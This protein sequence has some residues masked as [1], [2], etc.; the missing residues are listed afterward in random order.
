MIFADRMLYCYGEDGTM[1]LI[2]PDS[3]KLTLVSSFKI[4]DGSREHFAHPA[5]GDGVLYVRH[6]N[7]LMAYD[8]RKKKE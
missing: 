1:G 6:G 4:V 5:I 7:A 2:R 8:I 3:G